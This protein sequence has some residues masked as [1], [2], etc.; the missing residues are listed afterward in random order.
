MRALIHRY[1]YF[2][3]CLLA[4]FLFPL[5]QKL[6]LIPM[7]I[8]GV[9]WL[10][11]PNYKRKL[12]LLRENNLVLFLFGFYLIH[13][14]GLIWTSNMEAG[15]FS[16]EVRMSF[17]F[18]P[19]VIGGSERFSKGSLEWIFKTYILGVFVC[20]LICLIH[21]YIETERTGISHFNYK[22]LVDAIGI[23]M[24]YLSLY[25]NFALL[26]LTYFF[27]KYRKLDTRIFIVAFIL[28][29]I[30]F[31][32]MLGA[33]I[34]L[35]IMI[36]GFNVFLFFYFLRKP[37]WLFLILSLFLLNLFVYAIA[38][39]MEI[40]KRRLAHLTEAET[41]IQDLDGTTDT[42]VV[43]NGVNARKTMW[44]EYPGLIEE[45]WMIGTGTG[46][47]GDVL[48]AKWVE[49][50]FEPGIRDK[51]NLHNQ[52]LQ[53]WL[54]LGLP[55][56]FYLLFMLFL[57]FRHALFKKKWALLVFVLLFSVSM[58]TEVMF[59]IQLGVV[60]IVFFCSLLLA[61][62]RIDLYEPA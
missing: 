38:M 25:V 23:H 39:E 43:W 29:L 51:F 45:Y 14:I 49:I 17:L 47:V 58:M 53:T 34:Q 11:E 41:E 50:D 30:V 18:I 28:Y 42:I 1:I 6:V 16:L 22:R 4:V 24:V 35:M 2:F 20:S 54:T 60:F 56:I 31:N 46:D 37:N 13:F 33:R 27:F 61:N 12:E 62:D 26:L 40:T 10:V 19:L 55:G 36:L 59:G 9:N 5:H 44:M 57:F 3:S 15:W 48:Q 32:L 21:A 52:Y 7:I 8:A